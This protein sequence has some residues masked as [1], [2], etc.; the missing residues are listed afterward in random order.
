MSN[1]ECNDVKIRHLEDVIKEKENII[2]Q[3]SLVKSV[4]KAISVLFLKESRKIENYAS[5]L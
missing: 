5:K 2:A 4:F 1:Q 3:V